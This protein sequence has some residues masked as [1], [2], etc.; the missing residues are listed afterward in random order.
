MNTEDPDYKSYVGV[1]HLNPEMIR[2]LR[3]GLN[4]GADPRKFVS[5]IKR[6]R[7]KQKEDAVNLRLIEAALGALRFMVK[8]PDAGIVRWTEGEQYVFVETEKPK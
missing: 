1:R 4:N 8:N 6:E 5:K 3:L 7:V 2:T